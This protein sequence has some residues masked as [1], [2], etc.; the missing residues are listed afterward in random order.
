MQPQYR[1]KYL[2]SYVLRFLPY[3]LLNGFW[4]NPRHSSRSIVFS[5]FSAYYPH[6]AR[7]PREYSWRGQFRPCNSSVASREFTLSCS[8]H[9]HV[10]GRVRDARVLSMS[11]HVATDISFQ[12]SRLC[13][14][15]SLCYWVGFSSFLS[16][17]GFVV[18]IMEPLEIV[19]FVSCLFAF[20]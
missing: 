18:P 6:S 7:Y 4:I 13:P 12:F 14:S 20:V 1:E 9:H 2:R 5:E 11:K 3:Y 17:F 16:I 15:S 10:F 19:L 8:V